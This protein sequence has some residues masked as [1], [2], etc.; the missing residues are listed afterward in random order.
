MV[1]DYLKEID[2]KFELFFLHAVA[3]ANIGELTV[4]ENILTEDSFIHTYNSMAASFVI[5][6]QKLFING[7]MTSGS[8]VIGF[9]SEGS[10][11]V[12]S[13]YAAVAM[14]K[15]A[16]E[17]ACRY[18]SVDLA[19]HGIT[20]NLIGAGIIPSKALETL[21]N[22]NEIV[23]HALLRNPSG[24]LTNSDDIAKLVGFL[25]SENSAWITGQIIQSDGGEQL[26]IF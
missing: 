3:D 8:R 9:T 12:I 26:Q 16:L 2:E 23:Q 1:I 25:V 22:N 11:K 6:T 19:K 21:P 15:S 18:L 10:T 24:R 5:W 7:L 4:G 17:A 20:V 14:A 13:G